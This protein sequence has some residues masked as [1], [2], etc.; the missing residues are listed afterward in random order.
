MTDGRMTAA[1]FLVAELRRARTRRGWSQDDLAKAVNYSASM[2]SAIE[3]G[4]QPPTAK[5]LELAD[6]AL[7]TGGIFSRMLTD[8]VAL[9]RARVWQLGWRPCPTAWSWDVSAGRSVPRSSASP[10]S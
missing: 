6:R 2:V 5:Y 4:Q 9:D 1:A 3:L 7:D 8:L 10:T